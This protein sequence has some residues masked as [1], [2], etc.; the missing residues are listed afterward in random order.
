MW[1][2]GASAESAAAALRAAG[3]GSVAAIVIARH[4]NRG[5]RE[6]DLRLRRLAALGFDPDSCVLCAR[7]GRSIAG[8]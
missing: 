4:L 7:P 2:S 6:N 5:W 3:A 1:T 8:A